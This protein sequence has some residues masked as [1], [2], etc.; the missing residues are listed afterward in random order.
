MTVGSHFSPLSAASPRAATRL[1]CG[2]GRPSAAREMPTGCRLAGRS[3]HRVMVGW[4]LAM[5]ALLPLLLTEAC[6]SRPRQ[7]VEPLPASTSG[8]SPLRVSRPV[9][10]ELNQRPTL[11]SEDCVA[12]TVP[13]SS[14]SEGTVN[15][16]VLW[17]GDV[18]CLVAGTTGV[19]TM[20]P[21]VSAAQSH[22]AMRMTFE[23][24]TTMVVV[25]N[26]T[27]SRLRYRAHMR[28]P[29][30]SSFE[31]TT[32]APIASGLLGYETWPHPIDALA[33]SDIRTD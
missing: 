28:V 10:T 31:E 32:I 26:S 1:L 25:H 16:I 15:G 20:A 7:S 19:W 13:H 24:G 14:A 17:P 12:A 2:F 22:V 18:I 5:L 33:V 27:P 29:G 3:A 30:R 21:R 9:P 6:M 4:I 8:S 23:R 11:P